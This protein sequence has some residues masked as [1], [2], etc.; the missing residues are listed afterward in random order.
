VAVSAVLADYLITKRR[1]ASVGKRVRSR[2][3]RQ[4]LIA[5]F[6]GLFTGALATWFF[7]F[8][9]GAPEA[10]YPF[11]ML[12]YGAAVSSVGIFSQP[13]VGR[14]GAAFLAAGAITLL[15]G[16]WAPRIGDA[17]F[18]LVMTAISFGGFHIVYGASDRWRR[19]DR[20][21]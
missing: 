17:P 8:R 15:G 16:G 13:A 19:A 2:L 4:M 12:C 5:A 9:L 11:W 6:P 21:A 14:L 7:A 18:G 3:G 10:V 1:A 20:T